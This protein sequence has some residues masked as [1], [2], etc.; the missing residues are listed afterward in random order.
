[1]CIVQQH[2]RTVH[3]PK[4]TKRKELETYNLGYRPSRQF[5]TL[6]HPWLF[7][8]WVDN[9][10][11]TKQRHWD[12][13]RPDDE[14]TD[15]DVDDSARTARPD[16]ERGRF[17]V[18]HLPRAVDAVVVVVLVVVDVDLCTA[19]SEGEEASGR[20]TN[21][22]AAGSAWANLEIYASDVDD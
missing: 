9:F 11:R 7:E 5:Q 16:D 1:M 4:Q 20:W 10:E 6:T 2:F 15:P 13:A 21:A 17:R 22:G 19:G 12:S 3:P 8:E 14:A 18:S